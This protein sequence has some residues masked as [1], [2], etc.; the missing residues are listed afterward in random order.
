MENG[1]PQSPQENMAATIGLMY[2]KIT[3]DKNGDRFVFYRNLQNEPVGVKLVPNKQNELVL[4]IKM[5]LSELPLSDGQSLFSI[6][7]ETGSVSTG[8]MMS[9]GRSMGSM[10]QSNGGMGGRSGGGGGRGGGM[11]GGGG[12]RSGGKS[13]GSRPGGASPSGASPVKIW[14]QVQL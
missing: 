7:I 5:P 13:G 9:S 2:N 10:R 6:G 8:N 12:G 1:W 4:E 11:S 14:F 3:W